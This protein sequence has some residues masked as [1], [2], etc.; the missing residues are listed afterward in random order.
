MGTCRIQRYGPAALLITLPFSV[1]DDSP[2]ILDRLTA[3]IDALPLPGIREIVRG[4]VSLLVEFC[5]AEFCNFEAL[6]QIEECAAALNVYELPQSDQRFIGIPVQYDGPDLELVAAHTGLSVAE[7]VERH[8][9]ATYIV[10]FLGFA[11]GFPYLRGLDPALA[12]PRLGTP[13]PRVPP[14]SIGIGGSQTGI[15]SVATPGGWNLIGKTSRRLFNPRPTAGEAMF[16]LKPG[17]RIRFIAVESLPLDMESSVAEVDAE[18]AVPVFKVIRRSVGI[19][20]QGMGRYGWK[21]FGVPASGAV[22]RYALECANLLVGNEPGEPALELCLGGQQLEVL[23]S[24]HIAL[25]GADLNCV[26][27]SQGGGRTFELRSWHCAFAEAGSV[28]RFRNQAAGVWAYLAIPGG[29]H[30]KHDL[31]SVSGNDRAGLGQ[32]YFDS[33]LVLGRLRAEPGWIKPLAQRKLCARARPIEKQPPTLRV[34]PGPQWDWFS[35]EQREQFFDQLWTISTQLDRSGYRL[36]GQGIPGERPEMLSEPTM[37]G[38]I[39]ILPSGQPIVSLHDGPTV[40]GYP[41]LGLIHE[42]D[43]R[44]LVQTRAGDSVRFTIYCMN[45]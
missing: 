2:A 7:I 4:F 18:P 12:T 29:F 25:A 36:S 3:S 35:P 23:R 37:P 17:D 26:V 41:R 28:I 14:G 16:A 38:S 40:S 13:R 8:S 44:R 10:H 5:A 11:P 9:A 24:T 39:Q 43:L 15:Y 31:G 34:W 6:R 45:S 32:L 42:K 19:S 20:L 27:E 30:G 22:D 1:S 33:D 21:R